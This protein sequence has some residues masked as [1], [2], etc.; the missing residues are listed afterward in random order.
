[1]KMDRMNTNS[2]PFLIGSIDF[3]LLD[4]KRVISID[5]TFPAIG[6]SILVQDKIMDASDRDKSVFHPYHLAHPPN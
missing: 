2:M 3:S 6:V 5:E 1:M 4:Y